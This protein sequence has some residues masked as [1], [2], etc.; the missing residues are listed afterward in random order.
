MKKSETIT[1]KIDTEIPIDLLKALSEPNR[2]SLLRLLYDEEICVCNLAKKLD[3]AYNLTSFHLK[4]L[5]DEGLVEK[6]RD[7]NQI[8]YIIKDKWRKR[9]EYYFKFLD[10]N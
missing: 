9:L 10:I 6:K 5:F 7:K 1:K 3:L 2:I 8:F 4:V